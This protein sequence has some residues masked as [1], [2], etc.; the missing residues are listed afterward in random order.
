MRT[1]VVLKKLRQQACCVALL[2]LASQAH[3]ATVQYAFQNLADAG[4][5]DLW[6]VDYTVSGALDTFESINIL[7][8]PAKFAE[9]SEPSN[10]EP[11]LISAVV[12]PPVPAL[13]ADGQLAITANAA[14]PATFS[15]HTGLQFIW[16]GTGQPGPQAFEHLSEGFALLGSGSTTSVSTVPE[17]NV[18]WLSL[19]GALMS[20]LAVRRRQAGAS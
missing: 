2:A 17:I 9:L 5:G 3:A 20:A 6:Q 10:S 1:M 7:F 18:A 16:L 19:A 15:A 14:L 8:D 11:E 12:S 13:F 4:A